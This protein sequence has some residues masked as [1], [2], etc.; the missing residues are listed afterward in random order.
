MCAIEPSCPLVD[1]WVHTELSHQLLDC[2][3]LLFGHSYS[4]DDVFSVDVCDSTN[5]DIMTILVSDRKVLPT[6][7]M[8][9]CDDI[10]EQNEW[11]QEDNSE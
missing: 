3:A 8:N 11:S 10:W 2:R 1:R 5:T 7:C 9:V 4:P 6:V